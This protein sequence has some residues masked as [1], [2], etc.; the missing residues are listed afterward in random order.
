MAAAPRSPDIR[1]HQ[2]SS[3]QHSGGTARHLNFR[4]GGWG[5]VN[6]RSWN[7]GVS[8][9]WNLYASSMGILEFGWLR[10]DLGRVRSGKRVNRRAQIQNS[11]CMKPAGGVGFFPAPKHG[12]GEPADLSWK[13]K[14][15][16]LFRRPLSFDRKA[17]L[18][19]ERRRRPGERRRAAG[20]ASAGLL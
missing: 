12:G 8:G 17:S 20:G 10:F 6:Y 2:E 13:H 18:T 19:G 3:Q 9:S 14:R 5:G 15:P 1:K 4:G 16:Q 11:R 7:P